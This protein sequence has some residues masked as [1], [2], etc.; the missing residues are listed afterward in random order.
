MEK[1][2]IINLIFDEINEQSK[3]WRIAYDK[4]DFDKALQHNHTAKVLTDFGNK[5]NSMKWE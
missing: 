3:Q 4:K 2:K 5:I 1:Q